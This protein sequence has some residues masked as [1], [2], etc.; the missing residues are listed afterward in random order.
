MKKLRRVLGSKA[1]IHGLVLL[2]LLAIWG[3]IETGNQYILPRRGG[4][5]RGRAVR[6]VHPRDR[7]GEKAGGVAEGH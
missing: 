2:G 6:R 5:I 7:R 1:F 4:F 3:V